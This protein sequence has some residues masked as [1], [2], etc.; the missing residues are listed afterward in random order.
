ME[1]GQGIFRSHGSGQ[2]MADRLEQL[3]RRVFQ[4]PDWYVLSYVEEKRLYGY[5]KEACSIQQANLYRA[6][7]CSAMCNGEL[8]YFCSESKPQCLKY[9]RPARFN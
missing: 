9:V 3:I 2:K 8:C 7:D 5:C 4:I 1:I 6:L